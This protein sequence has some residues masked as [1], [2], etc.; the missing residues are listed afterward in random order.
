LFC[1]ERLAWD[2]RMRV[3]YRGRHAAG[4][5]GCIAHRFEGPAP[6]LPAAVAATANGAWAA[7]LADVLGTC[8]SGR[9]QKHVAQ[10]ST[11]NVAT[12]SEELFSW[13]IAPVPRA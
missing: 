7:E 4:A 5:G 12:P 2:Q 3:V 10:S 13:I 6:L 11:A 1:L 8:P 9:M